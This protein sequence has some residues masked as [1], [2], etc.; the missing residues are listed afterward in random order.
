MRRVFAGMAE[1]V[2]DRSTIIDA[3]RELARRGLIAMFNEVARWT[4]PASI[5]IHWCARF[6]VRLKELDGCTPSGSATAPLR[7]LPLRGPVF[8]FR[9]PVAYAVF[10]LISTWN[11]RIRLPKLPCNNNGLMAG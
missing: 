4:R 11:L 10:A 2:R 9:T 7:L 1:N 8:T 3:L 5:A 6:G